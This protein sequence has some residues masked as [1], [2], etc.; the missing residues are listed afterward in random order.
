[1]NKWLWISIALIIAMLLLTLYN[2]SKA[3]EPKDSVWIKVDTVL[4]PNPVTYNPATKMYEEKLIR[5]TQIFR[6][7]HIIKQDSTK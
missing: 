5:K 7:I 1:M 4:I 6:S 2:L 3:D